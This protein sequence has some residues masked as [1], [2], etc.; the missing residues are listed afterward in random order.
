VFP[1]APS[2]WRTARWVVLPGVVAVLLFGAAYVVRLSCALGHCTAPPVRHLLDLDAVGGLPR[3]F[4]TG[5]LAAGGM[6]AGVRCLSVTGRPRLWWAAVAA[7]GLGLAILKLVS[8]HSVVK[9]ETSPMTAL[10]LGLA[11][12][13]PVLALLAVA[14][15]TWG[16]AETARVVT[17]FAGYALAALGLDV[18]TSLVEAVQDDVGAVSASSATFVEELGEALAALGVLGVLRS[19]TAFSRTGR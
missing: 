5:V 16:I 18:L 10:L 6:L 12:A 2:S 3:L 11:V 17:A 9:A 15:R 7:T 14:G 13:V 4:T 1:T 8:A 19:A